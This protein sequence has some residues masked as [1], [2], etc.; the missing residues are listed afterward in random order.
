[1]DEQ[2][3]ALAFVA[4][5]ATEVIRAVRDIEHVLHVHMDDLPDGAIGEHLADQ[6]RTGPPA[7]IE[8]DAH[9]FASLV[10]R[11]KKLATL[12]RINGDGFFANDPATQLQCLDDVEGVECIDCCDNHGIGARFPDHLF[13]AVRPIG[14][15]SRMSP[16]SAQL[17][18]AISG[19]GRVGIAYGNQLPLFAEAGRQRFNKG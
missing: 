14:R 5:P 13:E 15:D 8:S 9:L 16:G 1:M 4:V 12:L 3:A 11:K 6:G 2:A 7:G 10:G 19:A 18:V 17:F